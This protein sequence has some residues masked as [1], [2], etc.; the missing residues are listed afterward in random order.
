[1]LPWTKTF[2]IF[3]GIIELG[4]LFFDAKQEPL[5]LHPP[6]TGSPSSAGDVQLF[7]MQRSP[8]VLALEISNVIA[9]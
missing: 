5:R 3:P 4:A 2:S 6:V 1:M 9:R 8:R 7:T